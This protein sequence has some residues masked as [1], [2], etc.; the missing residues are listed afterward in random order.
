[1]FLGRDCKPEA[2]EGLEQ[3]VV[4]PGVLSATEM[5]SQPGKKNLGWGGHSLERILQL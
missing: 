2:L 1:M 4:F 3:W 5:L